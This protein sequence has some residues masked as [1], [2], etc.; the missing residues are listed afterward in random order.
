[1]DESEV[2]LYKEK[3]L[4]DLKDFRKRM[5]KEILPRMEEIENDFRSLLG[6]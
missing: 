3:F 1:L 5:N 2:N 6:S 4:Q